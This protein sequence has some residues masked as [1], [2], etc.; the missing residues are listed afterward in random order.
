MN[1]I[2][3]SCVIIFMSSVLFF[4]FKDY[5]DGDI[6]FLELILYPSII[7]IIVLLIALM[8]NCNDSDH[9]FIDDH[10]C[11]YT[12]KSETV[13]IPQTTL[14]GKVMV[15]NLMPVTSYQWKCSDGKTYTFD[16]DSND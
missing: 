12:G 10:Q 1:L 13:Y 7:G 11:H 4:Y 6:D 14:V 5:R 8:V 16:F 15:T 3:T 2:G 9:K